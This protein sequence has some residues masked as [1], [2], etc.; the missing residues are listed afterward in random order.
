[1][2]V[3]AP[4]DAPLDFLEVVDGSIQKDAPASTQTGLLVHTG[5]FP[6]VPAPVEEAPEADQ[7]EL[8]AEL[9]ELPHAVWPLRSMGVL[10]VLSIGRSPVNDLVLPDPSV[11][12]QHASL[13]I[14][15]SQVQLRDDGSKN[16]TALNGSGLTA[17]KPR[18]LQPMDRIT[19]GRVRAFVCDPAALRA[20]LRSGLR[21]LF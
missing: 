12:G 11:S 14:D 4:E 8:L 9:A 21:P 7:I 1:M 2:V 16:G 17:G 18:W 20:V 13:I 19:F 3:A 6:T 10:R 5:E 15:G